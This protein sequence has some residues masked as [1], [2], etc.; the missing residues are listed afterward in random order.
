MNYEERMDCQLNQDPAKCLESPMERSLYEA[1]KT[2]GIAPIMQYKLDKYFLDLAF[3]DIKVAIEY[4]GEH[5]MASI[6]RIEKDNK[7]EEEIRNLGWDVIRISRQNNVFK[8]TVGREVFTHR[9]ID[10]ISDT[11]CF[12]TKNWRKKIRDKKKAEDEEKRRVEMLESL[13]DRP[14]KSL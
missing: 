4:D 12:A 3:P 10:G 5:H 7:R 11:I 1:L 8:I 14:S 9:S 6:E 13:K 2:D